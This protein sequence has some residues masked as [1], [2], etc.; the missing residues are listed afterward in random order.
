M[1]D[2]IPGNLDALEGNIG[3]LVNLGVGSSELCERP[4]RIPLSRL[5]IQFVPGYYFRKLVFRDALFTNGDNKPA[6]TPAHEHGLD[7]K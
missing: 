3:E 7:F 5:K 6:R 2:E 4:S 1:R